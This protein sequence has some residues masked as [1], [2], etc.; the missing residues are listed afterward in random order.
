MV[1]KNKKTALTTSSLALLLMLTACGG[2]QNMTASESSMNASDDSVSNPDPLEPI[3]RPIFHFNRFV[4]TIA[5]KPI[6][7]AYVDYTPQPAQ[8]GVRNF[9]R[10]LRTPTI[11]VNQLLQGEAV[12]SAKTLG[13]FL[14]NSTI[15][16][17][18]LIDVAGR[19]EKVDMKYETADF[20]QTL[21]VWGVGPGP[22]LMLPVLGPSTV[23]DGIGLA[24]DT[25]SDPLTIYATH[26]DKEWINW[27]RFGLT[28]LDTRAEFLPVTDDLEKNSL[29]Y[30]AG[31]RSM[32]LQRREALIN[33]NSN[34]AEKTNIDYPDYPE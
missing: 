17:G 27:S 4:D 29:D 31:L 2:N 10:N 6:A 13:R 16:V 1:Y 9:L 20:G 32:Y 33:K 7:R 15:G 19:F 21:G 11:M 28:I 24:A 12:K 25:F 34:G 18:G 26:D 23:R 30:Y 3:N 5:L 14:V 8:D 22:Y